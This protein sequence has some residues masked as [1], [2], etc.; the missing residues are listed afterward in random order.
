VTFPCMLPMILVKFIPHHHSPS[1]P[2]PTGLATFVSSTPGDISNTVP[3]QCTLVVL[4]LCSYCLCLPEP[5][6]TAQHPW[7][8]TE[9]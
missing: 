7:A 2:L 6:G 3:S 9:D 4:T 8:L 1:F 5:G